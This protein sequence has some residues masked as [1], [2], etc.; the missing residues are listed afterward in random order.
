VKELVFTYGTLLPGYLAETPVPLHN[1]Q[2]DFV[3]GEV[4]IGEDGELYLLDASSSWPFDLMGVVYEIEEQDLLALDD[5][6]GSKYR[7]IRCTTGKG[8]D[9]WV[10]VD[11]RQP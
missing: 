7:R 9:A 8:R 3:V 6:E 10:Y 2:E 11:N 5:Y 4:E 1:P